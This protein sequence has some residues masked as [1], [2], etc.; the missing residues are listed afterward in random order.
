[1]FY[2]LLFFLCV[3]KNVFCVSI[4][5]DKCDVEKN[6][7]PIV[8]RKIEKLTIDRL[9][10][11]PTDSLKIRENIGLWRACRFNLVNQ[12]GFGYFFKVDGK[13]VLP[14]PQMPDRASIFPEDCPWLW[15][16]K[17]IKEIE[18]ISTNRNLPNVD[19]LLSGNDA[20][21]PFNDVGTNLVLTANK[22]TSD[23]RGNIFLLPPF[24]FNSLKNYKKR[25]FECINTRSKK[26]IEKYS[27]IN[28]VKKA[29]WRGQHAHPQGFDELADLDLPEESRKKIH[30]S[31]R[32]K[33]VVLSSKFPDH[34]DC[35]FVSYPKRPNDAYNNML[36]DIGGVGPYASLED[37]AKYAYHLCLDGWA[38]SWELGG[39]LT[40][41]MLLG[42]L[43]FNASEY[44]MYFECALEPFVHYIPVKC[45][46]SDLIE[47]VEWAR[48]HPT[49]AEQIADNGQK[50]AEEYLNPQAVVDYTVFLLNEIAK[51]QQFREK[52]SPFPRLNYSAGIP[53]W[54]KPY[55]DLDDNIINSLR[56]K[57]D[58]LETAVDV[59]PLSK[60]ILSQVINKDIT[61]GY[62]QEDYHKGMIKLTTD[63]ESGV[64]GD[65]SCI[66]CWGGQHRWFLEEEK[67]LFIMQQYTDCCF[68]FNQCMQYEEGKT[69]KTILFGYDLE[70]MNTRFP[71]LI[72]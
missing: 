9:D 23:L 19:C 7:L 8:H 54:K 18:K 10:S 2:L 6:N 35:K 34:L 1:M 70:H 13:K 59:Y 69:W 11:L 39:R 17:A 58:L 49:E 22:K 45:D 60:K 5:N 15:A 44:E 31:T 51:R 63:E 30:K 47:K 40:E 57:F 64:E 21:F 53:S 38:E 32:A 52:V 66:A 36:H 42:N 16:H 12:K 37:Q 55:P 14:V 48:S 68:L 4:T 3:Q 62:A 56:T 65:A 50:F 67:N 25:Y 28:K 27:F 71:Y 33:S 20:V 29:F 72:F 26:E 43:C 61:F 24:I 41:G 46:L